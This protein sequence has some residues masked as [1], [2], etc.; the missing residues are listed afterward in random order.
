VVLAN[1]VTDSDS[2]VKLFSTSSENLEQKLILKTFAGRDGTVDLHELLRYLA[3]SHQCNEILLEAGATLS[4]AMLKAGLIDEIVA[5]VAPA[6][7]GSDAFPMFQLPGMQLLQEHVRLQFLDVA[8][9]G[10]DCR[11]RSLVLPSA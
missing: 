10:K 7:L 4:G 2:A 11:I 1:A 8:M 3:A 5:Y 9:L 6:I